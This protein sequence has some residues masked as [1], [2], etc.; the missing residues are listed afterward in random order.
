MF[1]F[2]SILI[3]RFS[4]LLS[5]LFFSNDYY[6]KHFGELE[7]LIKVK[8]KKL[9][10][11]VSFLVPIP[12]VVGLYFIRFTNIGDFF[13]Y[14]SLY[15]NP[16]TAFYT[17]GSIYFVEALLFLVIILEQKSIRKIGQSKQRLILATL[18]YAIL[19]ISLLMIF[20]KYMPKF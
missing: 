20:I 10:W 18:F 9:A 15:T 12:M 8:N 11:I 3:V 4:R 1:V 7:P 5:Y 14:L 6:T 19:I 17:L 16:K 13:W 2:G